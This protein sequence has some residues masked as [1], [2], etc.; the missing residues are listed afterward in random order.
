MNTTE[1]KKGKILKNDGRFDSHRDPRFKRLTR[2]DHKVKIDER[3]NRMFTDEDFSI[4]SYKDPFG[5]KSVKRDDSIKF[6]YNAA[7]S[8]GERENIPEQDTVAD[9]SRSDSEG[10]FEWEGESTDSLSDEQNELQ[11]G[12]KEIYLGNIWERNPLNSVDFLEGS[13][14]RRL[15]LMGLD[16]DNI[17]ADDLYVV[18]S[19]FLSSSTKIQTGESNPKLKK[20]S[21]YPSE[22]GKKRMEYEYINGPMIE[23]CDV[24]VENEQVTKDSNFEYEANEEDYE[25][26]RKYQVEKSLYYY[27]IVECDEISTAIKL[28][29]ELDGMEASFC[30]DGLEIRF[31]PDDIDEFPFDP[32]S[33]STCIPIKYKQ[34]DCFTSA[35]R[36]SRPTLTWDDTPIE[37]IKFLRKRFTPEELLKSDFE[38]YLGSSGSETEGEVVEARNNRGMR[39]VLLG[40]AMKLFDEEINENGTKNEENIISNYE[41]NRLFNG[42]NENVNVEIEFNSSLED[43]SMSLIAKGKQK[44]EDSMKNEDKTGKSLTPW[45]SY[46]EKRKLKKKE[47]KAQLRERI[48][49]QK[50]QREKGINNW[51]ACNTE[52]T[53]IND[54]DVNS[55]DDDRHF[56]MKKISLSEKSGEKIR[57]KRRRELIKNETS[58]FVQ[59]N[60]SGAI[61]DPRISKI[62][63]DA[64]YAIDPTNPVYK[65]TEFNRKLLQ[66]KRT[67][68]MKRSS[69]SL[70]KPKFN[71][72]NTVFELNDDFKLLNKK[73]EIC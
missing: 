4:I 9:D 34:P 50:L 57:S 13:E 53:I 40:D 19:S 59:K 33:V 52:P 8:S 21:I 64:D 11:E 28:Y 5:N 35:L 42:K 10:S 45:Q 41:I 32:I 22:F 6:L 48:K 30:I 1:T 70:N 63:T 7:E 55:S 31:V 36:H 3:F 25:A 61:N 54:K 23:K 60:F 12:E 65:S 72:K 58:N 20:I 67:Q 26:I 51:N 37:R 62:F 16:W 29:E 39:E 46:L 15:A 47:R 56:D 69:T 38:A 66:E 71:T 68:K 14:T 17:T 44:W 73:L 43:L 27:S 2:R 49:E 18:L 24:A